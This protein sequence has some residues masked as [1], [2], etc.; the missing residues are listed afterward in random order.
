MVVPFTKMKS[1]MPTLLITGANRGIGLRCAQ[2]Y[3]ADGWRILALCRHHSD[4]LGAIEAV[5][6]V[7]VLLG[8]LSDGKCLQQFASDLAG[9]SVDVLINNAGL[10]G[11][12]NYHQAGGEKQSLLDFNR[13]EWRK[14]FE[15]NLFTP[16][17]VI[18]LFSEH[19]SDKAKVVTIS[20]EMGSISGNKSGGW[21]AYRA[22][23]A[24]ANSL[25]K[26]VAFS[27]KDRGIPAVALHPG[28]VRTEMGGPN[29]HIDTDT[30]VKGMMK[31]INNLGMQQ[32]GGFF[33]Y[34]GS[35]LPY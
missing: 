12:S 15:I 28:W 19:L 33:A 23:K 27:L 22:S 34:D 24:A 32:S 1:N 20:S 17:E 6:N 8:D 30:S 14:V 18:S 2:R 29:A 13:E 4:E 26:S 16:V 7:R 25:M 11:D 35:V 3:H 10:M 5:G 31:V 9:E 21:F